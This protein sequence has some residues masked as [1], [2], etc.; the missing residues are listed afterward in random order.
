[1]LAFLLLSSSWS[2]AALAAD[3][4]VPESNWSGWYAG[5][6]AGYAFGRSEIYN[7][8]AGLEEFDGDSFRH[9]PEG[10][11]SGLALGYNWQPT[12][13]GLVFGLEGDVSSLHLNE[14]DFEGT[15]DDGIQT[16]ISGMGTLRGRLGYGSDRLHIYGTGGLALAHISQFAG[17]T[18]CDVDPCDG[19]DRSDALFNTGDWKLG[20]T[21]GAGAEY[22]A[23]G[24][25]IVRGEYLY[26]D[27]GNYGAVAP[28]DS[29]DT[30]DFKNAM[31]IARL[32]LIRQ[33]GGPS[34]TDGNGEADW[35][36]AHAGI[37]AGHAF[38]D[39]ALSGDDATPGLDEFAGD[40]FSHHPGGIVGGLVSGY[41]IM[42]FQNG[43]VLGVESDVSLADIDKTD[44]EGTS[45]DGIQTVISTLSTARARVGF[46]Q[47]QFHVYATGGL[48]AGHISQFAGD[49]DCTVDPC[50]GWDRDNAAFNTGDWKWGWTAGAGAEYRIGSNWRA[51]AEYLYVD[52]G[53]YTANVPRPDTSGESLTFDNTLHIARVGLILDL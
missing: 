35:V 41:S 18:D 34:G 15:T 7:D 50:N 20:W 36:G 12:G 21:L 45:D 8:D 19:W 31:H 51:R 1:V 13:G 43:L 6:L 39:A 33:F 14:T 48:A 44:F 2:G 40:S 10:F 22:R 29:S 47:E 24:N 9:K 42:P 17:D 25:W 26:V 37:T 30:G 16:I 38:G 11:M 3:P 23:F 32:G 5:S 52:L 27:L 49:T 46:A 53:K 4:L 28:N